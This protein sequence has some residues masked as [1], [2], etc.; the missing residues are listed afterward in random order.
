M[1]DPAE[2]ILAE[3]G[4]HALAATPADVEAAGH[5]ATTLLAEAAARRELDTADSVSDVLVWRLWLMADLPADASTMP[6]TGSRSQEPSAPHAARPAA[7]RQ[8]QNRKGR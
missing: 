1:P 3:P 2:Q 6:V 4:W 5:D 7:A 8:D